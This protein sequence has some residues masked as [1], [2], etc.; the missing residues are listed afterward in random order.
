LTDY[1]TADDLRQWLGIDDGDDDVRLQYAVTAASRAVEKYCGQV[2]NV[3]TTVS[4]RVFH[5]EFTHKATVDP[6][7]TTTGLI[8]KIDTAANGTY[9]QTWTLTTDYFVGPFNGI[10][11]G[12]SGFPYTQIMCA[13]QRWFP[14]WTQR[15]LLQV[16]AKGG[17][18][19]VPDDVKFAC[20]LKAAKLFRRHASP[21]AIAGGLDI[22]AIR[23]SKYEDP[24]V[25]Q[26]LSPYMR[27]GSLIG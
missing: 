17:W 19:A 15:P 20:R 9:D 1:I 26:L 4:A 11:D 5:N 10:V 16:T 14:T 27:M 13:P 18:P 7:S 8:V 2:F 3:D 6:F 12:V 25:C 23:I 22:G 24:D 21:D